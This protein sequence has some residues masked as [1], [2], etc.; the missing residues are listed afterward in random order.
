[1]ITNI[2]SYR[3]KQK[4]TRING[5]IK[6]LMAIHAEISE[7]ILE[8]SQLRRTIKELAKELKKQTH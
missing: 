4:I 2:N 6:E 1:M 7:L 5:L 8:E 3:Q